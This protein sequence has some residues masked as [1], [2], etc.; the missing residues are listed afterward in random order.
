VSGF[1]TQA[2]EVPEHIWVLAMCLRIT[3]LGVDETRELKT[4]IS[5]GFIQSIS[6]G[7]TSLKNQDHITIGIE[8]EDLKIGKSRSYTR[9][10][11]Y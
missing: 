8:K 3:L 4:K 6:V 9:K 7:K 1:W 5:T 10:C 2:E 11:P